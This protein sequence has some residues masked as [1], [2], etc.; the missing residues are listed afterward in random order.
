M[1]YFQTFKNFRLSK[2]TQSVLLLIAVCLGLLIARMLISHSR[3]FTFLAWNLFLAW[4][5]L[6]FSLIARRLVAKTN[7]IEGRLLVLSQVAL[8]FL[9]FPNAPYIITDLLH[10][11]GHENTSLWFDSLMIFMFALTGLMMGIYSLKAIQDVFEQLIGRTKTRFLMP[12]CLL[13][14][15]FG[16][17]LGRY[18]R[19]NSW[20]IVFNPKGL[21]IDI[22]H[23]TQNP[24][25]I[26][27]SLA[28]GGVLILCYWAFL[29]LRN[30]ERTEN[31]T[32]L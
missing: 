15:G 30:D 32:K 31:V 3:S 11:Q 8:W 25:A 21:M 10:L 18:S 1:A 19:W 27:V 2:T 9:F 20:D 12:F 29:I 16:I 24:A 6:Y 5:P 14:S 26:K 28:F 13:L 4:L 7:T 22:Y 17:Y 23:Q